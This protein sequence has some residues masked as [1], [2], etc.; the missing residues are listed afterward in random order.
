MRLTRK[1]SSTLIGNNGT[2]PCVGAPNSYLNLALLS[3]RME[4]GLFF[5]CGKGFN[6]SVQKMACS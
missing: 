5:L 6:G 4:G 1:C 2:K 3:D